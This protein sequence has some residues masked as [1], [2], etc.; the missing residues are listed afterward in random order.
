[1]HS[2]VV[3][4]TVVVPVDGVVYSVEASQVTTAE[5]R[6]TRGGQ[7]S[8]KSQ[9]VTVLGCAGHTVSVT[10]TQLCL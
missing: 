3:W 6:L 1:M 2:Q 8:A 4:L 10:A 9:L 7:A 5:P